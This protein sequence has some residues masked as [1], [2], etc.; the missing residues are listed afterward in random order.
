MD[1]LFFL[2][3]GAIVGCSIACLITILE[4]RKILIWI[5]RNE[6]LKTIVR[7]DNEEL[8]NPLTRKGFEEVIDELKE[9][10]E[11]EADTGVNP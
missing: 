1:T 10:D 9:E 6:L 3:F 4:I 2:L 7:I 8:K 5:K 11:K